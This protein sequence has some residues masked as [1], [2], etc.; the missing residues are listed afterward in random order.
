MSSD[1]VLRVSDL[2][3]T[4]RIS[5]ERPTSL[6]ERFLGLHRGVQNE[7]T[8]L[9]DISFEVHQGEAVGI[10]GH[11]G[12]G[13]STLMKCIA[14]IM[15]PTRGIVL[16]AGRVVPLLEL[17]AGF[18]P[19]L[20]GRDNIHMNAA[21][22]GLSPKR[23]SELFDSIVEF[24]ELSEFLEVP[25]RHYS[26]GMYARL[27]FS[28]AVHVSPE[29]VI[30]DEVLAV[31]DEAFQKKCLARVQELLRQGSTMLLVSHSVQQVEEVCSRALV[32]NH[33]SLIADGSPRDA[34]ATYR[35]TIG[36]QN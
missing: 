4:F 32:L 13:K 20:S 27:G 24:S 14:G 6:K 31:G 35:R 36:S 12:S 28:I 29:I 8:A 3:K 16:T 33:G 30:F 23:I 17:G 5:T 7:F 26:S 34:G 15:F 25:V 22:L 21:I 10:L 18:Q 19:D 11:N 2:T 9:K 1:V